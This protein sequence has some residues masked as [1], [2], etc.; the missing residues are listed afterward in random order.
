LVICENY[1]HIG[2][3]RYKDL[4]SDEFLHRKPGLPHLMHPVVSKMIRLRTTTSAAINDVLIILFALKD[5]ILAV[6]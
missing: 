3:L 6:A 2:N 4:S 1:F 5:A